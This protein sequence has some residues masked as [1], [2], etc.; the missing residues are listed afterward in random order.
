MV[1]RMHISSEKGYSK[2]IKVAAAVTGK[3]IV[4]SIALQ[5]RSPLPFA[6]QFSRLVN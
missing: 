2:A 6:S 1:I 4:P 3:Y 5:D